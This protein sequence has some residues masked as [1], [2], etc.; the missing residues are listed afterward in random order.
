MVDNVSHKLL[1]F[2]CFSDF[3]QQKCLISD[4]DITYTWASIINSMSQM[5]YDAVKYKS[6]LDSNLAT[7]VVAPR[8]VDDDDEQRQQSTTI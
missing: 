8:T 4:E 7:V 5:P 2:V 1:F 3:I 6:K